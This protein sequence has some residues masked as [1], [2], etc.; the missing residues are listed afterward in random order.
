MKLVLHGLLHSHVC[1]QFASGRSRETLITGQERKK[2]GKRI[3]GEEEEKKR[4]K[5]FF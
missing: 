3:K 1:A 4:E 2:E 5:R